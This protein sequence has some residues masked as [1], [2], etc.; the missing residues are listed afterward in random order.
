M[1]DPRVSSYLTS[2]LCNHE[3]RLR[4]SQLGDLLQLPPEQIEQI[5]QEEPHRFSVSG[6]LVLAR[7]AM[8]ICPDYLKQ[9]EE[10]KECDKLHLCRLYLQG[11]CWA[12][13]GRGTDLVMKQSRHSL[14]SIENFQML[15]VI[16]CNEAVNVPK[17]GANNGAQCGPSGAGRGRGRGRGRGKY[18]RTRGTQGRGPRRGS[19]SSSTPGSRCSTPD[20]LD[21]EDDE[22]GVFDP[23]SGDKEEKSAAASGPSSS[24]GS[25]EWSSAPQPKP[26]IL[27]LNRN[28]SSESSTQEA[29]SSRERHKATGSISKGQGANSAII[30]PNN[31]IPTGTG[32]QKPNSAIISPTTIYNSM[33]T[34]KDTTSLGQ[35]V[36]STTTR[37]GNTAT[38][39]ASMEQKVN[40]TTTNPAMY[41]TTRTTSVGQKVN[42][43]LPTTSTYIATGTA[44]MEQKV[45]STTTNPG[46]YPTIGTTSVGQKVNSTLPT[47]STYIATGTASMEQKVNSTTTNPG[48]YP[49]IGT[50]YVEQKVNSTT[51][52]PGMYPTIGT[53]YVEQKVNST[54]P[55]TPTYRATGAASMEQ[56]V[57][58]TTTNPAMYPTTR[59]TSVAQKVNSAAIVNSAIAINMNIEYSEICL[60]HIWKHCRLGNK[61]G[62]MH[63]HLPYRWQENLGAGWQ[64]FSHMDAI[65]RAFCQPKN[66]SY[67]GVDFASMTYRPI[68]IRRLA[69]PS[70]ATR[71]LEFVLT[72]EWLWYWQD[73]LGTWIEYGKCNTKQVGASI[74]SSDLESIYLADKT[75]VVP[76]QAGGQHYEISFKDMIQRN[77]KYTTQRRIRRRPKYQS[78]E[79]VQKLKGTTKPIASS[80]PLK[81]GNYPSD[82]DASAL[83]D[84]GSMLVPVRESSH[85]YTQILGLFN[86]TMSGQTVKIQRIQN[87]SLWEVYQWQ[88]VQMQKANPGK[89]VSEMQL[90]HGT[91]PS[92]RAAICHQNFDWRV[93]GTN[94]TVYGQ[95]SYFARDASYSHNYSVPT[96]TGRRMMFVARVLVG[97]YVRGDPTMK[98]PPLRPGSATQCY[99][100]CVDTFYNPSIFVVFEKHQI[101]P[102]YLLEYEPKKEEKS[103]CIS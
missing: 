71:S 2:L 45:N 24:V 54:L 79:D 55:A 90:F 41:P 34:T 20:K 56:K 72:T 84:I 4:R 13:R 96:A 6:D 102:E 8:R 76:F 31:H 29:N 89:G 83:P 26:R 97:D 81:N 14:V 58:S 7:T 68:R 95:G 93:C 25:T 50:T 27:S 1:S 48:M 63:Y 52:N 40:S 35:K 80:S 37:I 15:C 36:S 99:D 70:S 53:T 39:A 88:K 49:A 33:Y 32:Q 100:S 62:E 82:W 67:S 10:E 74:T 22:D 64:D 65:E 12:A 42:S 5:L 47:T 77:I 75:A 51:T 44:S 103:C 73:E 30:S 66:D 28:A 16:K 61:C 87:K 38:G 98:R 18:Q 85:E 57:N 23:P 92:H 43:T 9:K 60:H 17:K 59:T 86:K 78:S 101:Y 3:G 19:R 46:M 69:T 91:D 21:A 94:G 11:K